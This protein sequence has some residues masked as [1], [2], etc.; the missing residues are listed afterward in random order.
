MIYA[1]TTILGRVE[2]GA[3]ST[4]GGNVWLLSDVPADSVVVQ[5]EAIRLDDAA[6]LDL[7]DVLQRAA[8]Q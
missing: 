8:T 3:R 2:I 7:R 5:P 1:G 6:G 4:I